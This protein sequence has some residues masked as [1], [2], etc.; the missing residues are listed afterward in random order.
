MIRRVP[1]D[2]HPGPFRLDGS[3]NPDFELALRRN[4]RI[5]CDDDAAGR[6]ERTIHDQAEGTGLSVLTQ[7]DHG[8]VEIRIDEL[9]HRYEERGSERTHDVSFPDTTRKSS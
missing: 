7:Q 5:E 3:A 6:D 9:R 2:E 8:A 1:A 4:G